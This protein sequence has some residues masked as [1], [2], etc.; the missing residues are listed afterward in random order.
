MMTGL[1][2]EK[3]WRSKWRWAAVAAQHE[4]EYEEKI[5]LKNCRGEDLGR[6]TLDERKILSKRVAVIFVCKR[7]GSPTNGGVKWLVCE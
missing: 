7:D 2:P 5:L 6:F 1:Q 3:S 4:V